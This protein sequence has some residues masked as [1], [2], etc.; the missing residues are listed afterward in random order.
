MLK[1][2]GKK[3]IQILLAVVL[4]FALPFSVPCALHAGDQTPPVQ[5]VP[6]VF[7]NAAQSDS[8]RSGRLAERFRQI[9]AGAVSRGRNTWQIRIKLC[10][11]T[12]P[13]H[14]A[15]E[16]DRNKAREL[17][18]TVPLAF[19]SWQ[20][21][22]LA[23]N[24]LMAT[25]IFAQLGGEFAPDGKNDSYLLQNHWLIRGLARK[26]AGDTLFSIRPFAR[27]S[28]G[29][30]ALWSYGCPIPLE[31]VVTGSRENTRNLLSVAELESELAGLLV[32]ACED[33]GFFRQRLAEPVLRQALRS[34]D[35]DSWA[36]FQQVCAE[37][38]LFQGR[39]PEIWFRNYA[40]RRLISMLSPL[41]VEYFETR[42]REVT[43][44]SFANA[45]GTT[46]RC[47]LSGMVEN[48]Q[49]F[50]N[51]NA[52][53]DELLRQLNILSYRAPSGFLSHI[54]AIRRALSRLRTEQTPEA[55]SD[56]DKAEAGLF[57][58]IRSRIELEYYLSAAE[59]RYISPADRFERLLQAVS[60]GHREERT[61][62]PH[63]QQKLDKWDEYK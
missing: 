14:F 34:T 3:E 31:R 41:S 9:A 43:T 44:L 7:E 59:Q 19:E 57:L 6:L 18:V 21:D 50:S 16:P 24:W 58:V 35:S 27:A 63:L 17:V 15:A 54:L 39:D 5:F 20:D 53:I 48:W 45:D 8:F 2:P 47:G 11:A 32:E 25:L 30:Y 61:L 51:P 22:V 62:M 4:L 55:Q 36:V 33:A 12:E 49:R 28:V 26:A 29:A 1:D 52:Q 13:Q 23:H 56:L 38:N 37:R 40:D 10:S 60:A 42:Y 46:G